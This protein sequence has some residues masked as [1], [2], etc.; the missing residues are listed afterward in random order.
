MLLAIPLLISPAAFPARRFTPHFLFSMKP[1]PTHPGV[2]FDWDGV[3]VDSSRAH[4]RSWEIL[5]EERNL[6][7]SESQFKLGF[8]KRNEEIIPHIL[9]W[10]YD[11]EEIKTLSDRKEEIF[12]KIISEEG[13]DPLPGV[14]RL[15][16]D[17]KQR[18]IPCA[19]GTST[20][21]PNIELALELMDLQANFSGI[22]T[23]E[24]V[25]AGK[26]MPD[27]FLQAARALDREPAEVVVFEDSLAGIEAGIAGGFKVIAVATTNPADLLRRT[28]AHYVAERLT[29][30]SV[31]LIDVLLRNR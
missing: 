26:P 18:K 6:L 12:R 21:R 30:V 15:L 29:E 4:F 24:C 28:R 10:S 11:P 3:I 20:C 14:R 19:V 22:V 27:V 5:A 13:L 1:K 8:G 25:S 2:I 17:L 23:E 16:E 31:G 9:R 7:L